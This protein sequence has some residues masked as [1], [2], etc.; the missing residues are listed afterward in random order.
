MKAKIFCSILVLIVGFGVVFVLQNSE[1]T[2]SNNATF[3]LLDKYLNDRPYADDYF[4]D[5]G[6]DGT[7][8]DIKFICDD[9]Q[10][11]LE[12]HFG[13]VSLKFKKDDLFSK[14]N[15]DRLEN[16]GITFKRNKT[17]GRIYMY[18]RDQKVTEYAK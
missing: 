6:W 5:I 2:N 15:L 17:T 18:W 7:V 13:D 16:I 9:K 1:A 14:D 4:D 10:E 3:K 8:D 11:H 12:L